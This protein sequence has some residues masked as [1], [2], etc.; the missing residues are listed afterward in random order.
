MSRHN[1]IL[2][3]SIATST[4][5]LI[6]FIVAILDSKSGEVAQSIGGIIGGLIGAAGATVSVFISIERQRLSDH[7]RLQGALSIEIE[8]IF[9]ETIII[10]KNIVAAIQYFDLGAHDESFYQNLKSASSF[11]DLIVISSMPMGLPQLK[12]GPEVLRLYYMTKNHNNMLDQLM[13][14]SQ[15]ALAAGDR[16]IK[17]KQI[18]HHLEMMGIV[19]TNILTSHGKVASDSPSRYLV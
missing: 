5:T 19:C 16:L 10:R 15:G 9:E 12:S 18:E 14:A 4:I 13:L 7:E 2:L 8:H 1:Y 6:I 11:H 3:F 17:L